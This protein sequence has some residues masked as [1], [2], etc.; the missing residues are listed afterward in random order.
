M[1]LIFALLMAV[2]SLPGH[3]QEKQPLETPSTPF[4]FDNYRKTPLQARQTSV[5]WASRNNSEL[6]RGL[7][8]GSIG[9]NQDISTRAAALFPDPQEIPIRTEPEPLP[10]PQEL[11]DEITLA[12]HGE[13]TKGQRDLLARSR[14]ADQLDF[15]SMS[16]AD[17]QLYVARYRAEQERV[18]PVSRQDLLRPMPTLINTKTDGPPHGYS[19]SQA[20]VGARAQPR[21]NQNPFEDMIRALRLDQP[22]TKGTD[23]LPVPPPRSTVAAVAPAVA[24]GSEAAPVASEAIP[25]ADQTKP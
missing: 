21:D 15:S 11:T 16:E 3:A 24:P 23:P 10:S 9:K 13:T 5:S 19:V 1:A 2:L 7:I 14:V 20:G 4:D 18:S 17:Y 22:V 8:S 6:Q 25:A 12:N